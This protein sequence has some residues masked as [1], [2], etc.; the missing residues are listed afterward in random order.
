MKKK[1]VLFAALTIFLLSVNLFSH[2]QSLSDYLVGQWKISMDG[3]GT[4]MPMVIS[5]KQENN[6]LTGTIKIGEEN[7]IQFSKIEVKETLVVLIFTS[8]HDNEIEFTLKKV[9]DDHVSGA[10][11]IEGMGEREVNGERITMD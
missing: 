11:L 5:L 6:K 9:D 8:S 1:S 2:A 7:E 3:F 4:D 10:M